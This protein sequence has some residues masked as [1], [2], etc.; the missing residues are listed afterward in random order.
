MEKATREKLDQLLPRAL[1]TGSGCIIDSDGRTS[2]QMDVVI[3][4]RFLCP[5]F[6]I[7]DNPETTYYPCEGVV[8]V[9]E[10]KSKVGK[11]E[12]DDSVKKMESVKGLKRSFELFSDDEANAGCLRSS[13]K[14]GQMEND[15]ITIVERHVDPR[16]DAKGDILTFV[17][18]DK[19][20]VSVD[21]VLRYYQDWTPMF[22]DILISLE[23]YCIY[24]YKGR[25]SNNKH[26]GTTMRLAEGIHTTKPRNPFG[27]LIHLLYQWFRVGI[28]AELKAF[29]KYILK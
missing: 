22:H 26:L 7:N 5:V 27:N 13:R 10:I 12:F 23:G 20:K 16:I 17:L 21:T 25:D 1:A 28:T 2:R 15:G 29:E 6:C 3:Y 4:E 19:L 18:T 11:S 24:G 14:Y 8:A 9:G